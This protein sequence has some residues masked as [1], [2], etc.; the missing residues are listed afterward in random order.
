[1]GEGAA[2]ASGGILPVVEEKNREE[3][4]GSGEQYRHEAVKRVGQVTA[5][6][7]KGAGLPELCANGVARVEARKTG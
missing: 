7:K 2:A 4:K 6:I 5:V 3:N 1:M